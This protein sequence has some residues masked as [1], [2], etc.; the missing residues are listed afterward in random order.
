[1]KR[2]ILTTSASGAGGLLEARPRI[3]SFPWSQVRLG[4][5]AV[6][7]ELETCCHLARQCMRPRAL[8]GSISPASAS[9]K[10]GRRGRVGRILCRFE[11]VDLW[12][13]PDPNAQLTLIWLLDYL[14]HHA[15]IVSKL[16]LVQADVSIG[17]CPPEELAGWRLPAVKIRNDH[18]EAASRPGRPIA[19]RRRRTGSICSARTSASCRNLGR[20]CWNCS[21][22]SRWSRRDLVRRKC[23]C[24][25]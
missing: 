5:I 14:R 13:D 20:A 1:M 4:A 8:T 10:C 3:A 9:R 18:L 2:L 24:W 21:K 25:N 19:N 15:E 17:N 16:T 11:A 6:Q 22:N 7:I 12:V 23:G